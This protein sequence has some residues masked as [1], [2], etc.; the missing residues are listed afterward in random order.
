MKKTHAPLPSSK[1][2]KVTKNLQTIKDNKKWKNKTHS[3][4]PCIPQ[5]IGQSPFNGLFPTFK[6]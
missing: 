5:I 6:R 1:V 3:A 2:T 4:P